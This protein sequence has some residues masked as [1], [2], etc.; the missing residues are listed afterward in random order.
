V[1]IRVLSVS[2]LYFNKTESSH[3]LTSIYVLLSSTINHD[4]EK[5]GQINVLSFSNTFFSTSIFHSI[6]FILQLPF[7]SLLIQKTVHLNDAAALSVS[8]LNSESCS[9]FGAFTQTSHKLSVSSTFVTILSLFLY[10]KSV[11]TNFVSLVSSHICN[12]L[13]SDKY[14]FAIH[15]VLIFKISHSTISLIISESFIFILQE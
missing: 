3:G 1:L 2:V 5:S 8:I 6:R 12:S 10:F 15:H 11:K 4:Q 13:Q 7:H 9:N 14:T